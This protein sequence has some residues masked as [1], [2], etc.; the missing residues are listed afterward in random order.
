MHGMEETVVQE[1]GAAYLHG[2]GGHYMGV[3]VSEGGLRG[4][5]YGKKGVGSCMGA[6]CLLSSR[7]HADNLG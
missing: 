2:C 1:V 4:V 7:F 5:M 6:E 3:C